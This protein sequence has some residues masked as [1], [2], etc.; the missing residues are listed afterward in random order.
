MG[1]DADF[2]VDCPSAGDRRVD[3]RIRANDVERAVVLE[4]S[5]PVTSNVLPVPS[6]IVPVLMNFEWWLAMSMSSVEPATTLEKS[7]S[8]T[9]P[10]SVTVPRIFMSATGN[11]CGICGTIAR[12]PMVELRMSRVA[13]LLWLCDAIEPLQEPSRPFYSIGGMGETPKVTKRNKRGLGRFDVPNK[14]RPR[15]GHDL[16]R[17]SSRALPNMMFRQP[18]PWQGAGGS[19]ALRLGWY[20]PNGAQVALRHCIWLAGRPAPPTAPVGTPPAS[21]Q[22][23]D[24]RSFMHHS[25]RPRV[26]A[27]TGSVVRSGRHGGEAIIPQDVCSQKLGRAFGLRPGGGVGGWGAEGGLNQAAV[28]FQGDSLGYV[29]Q[30]PVSCSVPGT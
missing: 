21:Q 8:C 10:S 15:L 30:N 4:C 26:A 27:G 19:P 9:N 7:P 5:L 12:L 16:C 22:R 3:G 18:I 13:G 14:G 23:V 28:I 17:T 11:C 2:D 29:S 24:A 25:A 20:I 1:I 6:L